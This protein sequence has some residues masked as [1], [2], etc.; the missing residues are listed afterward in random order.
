MLTAVQLEVNIKKW[1]AI[2]GSNLCK[3]SDSLGNSNGTSQIASQNSGRSLQ[4]LDLVVESWLKL[5]LPLQSA[6]LAIV[7]SVSTGEPCEETV[8]Q[9]GGVPSL[10]SGGDERSEPESLI[11]FPHGVQPPIVSEG[12]STAENNQ[13]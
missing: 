8:S 4:S 10:L 12:K 1:C 13:R 6:I 9:G 11:K 3:T 7:Q 5:S 2:Q